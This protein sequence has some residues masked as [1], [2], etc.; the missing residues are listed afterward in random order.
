MLGVMRRL[1]A[2]GIVTLA[3]VAATPSPCMFVDEAYH[4]SS[5]D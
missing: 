3:L 2:N 1:D 5:L 4:S